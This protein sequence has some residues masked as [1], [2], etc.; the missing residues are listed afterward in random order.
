MQENIKWKWNAYRKLMKL[1]FKQQKQGRFSTTVN[2]KGI[3]SAITTI[4]EQTHQLAIMG[5]L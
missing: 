4:Y 3:R 2:S 1:C 5:L